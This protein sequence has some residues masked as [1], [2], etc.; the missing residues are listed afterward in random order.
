VLSFAAIFRQLVETK[1]LGATFG[2][3]F[4]QSETFGRNTSVC[5][6]K[7]LGMSKLLLFFRK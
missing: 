7:L 4:W 2:R 3:N 5:K 1:L 6:A